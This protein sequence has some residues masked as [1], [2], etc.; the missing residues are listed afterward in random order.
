MKAPRPIA[1][2]CAG[3][4]RCSLGFETR[5]CMKTQKKDDPFFTRK[6]GVF[7]TLTTR[8]GA[9]GCI[10]NLVGYHAGR[11]GRPSRSRSRV[12]RSALRRH[13]RRARSPVIEISL[14]RTG[15]R[16]QLEGHPPG[17]DGIILAN[18]SRRAVLLPPR[19][20]RT[21]MDLETTLRRLR[22]SRMKEDGYRDSQTVFEVFQ[23]IRFSEERR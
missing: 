7:V 17:V 3:G 13:Q 4:D 15:T 12:Q 21:G 18:A 23:A 2:P 8:C 14:D 11:P 5:R 10:G 22:Q 19:R 20:D 16:F 6:M 1:C 9:L